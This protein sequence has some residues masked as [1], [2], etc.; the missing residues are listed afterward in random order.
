MKLKYIYGISKITILLFLMAISPGL[1]EA[2]TGYGM[3][4][5]KKAS[6]YGYTLE[7]SISYKLKSGSAID[8]LK[9]F[10]KNSEYFI[11]AFTEEN[12]IKDMD[13]Y[14]YSETNRAIAKD[15]E[16]GPMGV[17]TYKPY[18]SKELKVNVKNFE[19]ESTEKEYGVILYIFAKKK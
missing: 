16:Y 10:E 13:L 5:I 12:E 2:Q 3:R 6:S 1:A 7:D 19:S 14:I 15:I 9:K 8:K 11:V 18:I 4:I 17:I